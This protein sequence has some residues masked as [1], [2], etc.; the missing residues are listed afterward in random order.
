M[1]VIRGKKTAAKFI[2]ELPV[3]IRGRLSIH[4]R[5]FKFFKKGALEKIILLKS[6][7]PKNKGIIINR[8]INNRLNIIFL[9]FI[10]VIRIENLRTVETN[11]SIY[12]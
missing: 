10:G 1:R 3:I 7:S 4:P 11:Y 2:I 6:H 5:I 8:N 12:S 9:A